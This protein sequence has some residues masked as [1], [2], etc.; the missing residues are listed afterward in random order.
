MIF[1]KFKLKFVSFSKSII[2]MNNLELKCQFELKKIIFQQ[3]LLK[4]NLRQISN[5]AVLVFATELKN[6]V[7][8]CL[9]SQTNVK[10]EGFWKV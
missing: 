6:N 7:D 2:L 4:V 3:N 5:R 10:L 1:L 9:L 8:P